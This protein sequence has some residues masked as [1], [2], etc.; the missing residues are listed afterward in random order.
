M[1][2]V[3]FHHIQWGKRTLIMRKE[4][5]KKRRPTEAHQAKME[6]T[7]QTHNFYSN[8]LRFLNQTQIH[9][10]NKLNDTDVNRKRFDGFNRFCNQHAILPSIDHYYFNRN[11]T[12]GFHTK[13]TLIRSEIKSG[14]PLNFQNI[15]GFGS[16]SSS[17]SNSMIWPIETA[18]LLNGVLNSGRV[19]WICGC[20][21]CC[22]DCNKLSVSAVPKHKN[23]VNKYICVYFIFGWSLFSIWQSW[24]NLTQIFWLK[25]QKQNQ[26]SSNKRIISNRK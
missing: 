24:I 10:E 19:W 14:L 1:K 23:W 22:W 7:R 15:F 11:T 26:K 8:Y 25:I 18:K 4:K 21:C 17:Q 20:C 13:L 16:P 2:S 5:K 3:I 6:M 9:Y 12:I